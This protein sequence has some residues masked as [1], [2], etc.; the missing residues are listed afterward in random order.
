MKQTYYRSE[1][2]EAFSPR[3]NAIYQSVPPSK[4]LICKKPI[5]LDI[6][7]YCLELVEEAH[8]YIQYIGRLCSSECL[9]FYI[10]REI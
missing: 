3:H 10:L 4:C 7:Y 2:V 5:S 9:D 1:K 6:S 8:I